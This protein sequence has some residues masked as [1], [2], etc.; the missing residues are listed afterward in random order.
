M[1][2]VRVNGY[3]KHF[4]FIRVL[5]GRILFSSFIFTGEIQGHR[6]TGLRHP[7]ATQNL[8]CKPFGILVSWV[9]FQRVRLETMRST[10]GE[11]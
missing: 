6:A 9:W 10:A 8:C 3:L 11:D 1:S 2:A 7:I 4:T 5:L